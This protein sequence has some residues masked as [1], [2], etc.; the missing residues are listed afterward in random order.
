MSK[1]IMVPVHLDGFFLEQEQLAVEAFA[2][3]SELPFSG[4]DED[5]NPDTANIS[6]S[7]LS[8]PFQNTNL[9]LKRGM[10]LH[11]SLPDALTKGGTGG[12]ADDYPAVPNRWLIKR[13]STTLGNAQWVV[14]SDYMTSDLTN[15]ND[16]IAYPVDAVNPSD[17]PFV[18]LG[19]RL[20]ATGWTEVS[21]TR[22]PRLTAM[23]Y[24]EPAFA[25]FYPNCHSVFGCFDPNVDTEA[26][27]QGLS[28]QLIG[29]Y[30]DTT[31]DPLL[32]LLNANSGASQAT[33]E[34]AIQD[35]FAWNV[36]IDPLNLPAGM[37]CYA[38][39]TFDVAAN[40][41]LDNSQKSQSTTVSIGN[42]GTEA[43]SAY[44]AGQLYDNILQSD[45]ST[46]LTSIH[47]EEQLEN[48]LL[49]TQLQ[50]G[51][52]DLGARF[53]EARHAKGFKAVKGGSLWEIKP[54]NE[55]NTATSVAIGLPAGMSDALDELNS[56]QQ[57]ADQAEEMLIRQ[58][59]I[60]F[61]DWYKYM[62][63]AYPPDD[64]RDDYPDIDYVKWY[65]Q[66]QSI[67]QVTTA[68]N[69]LEEKQETLPLTQVPL[70]AQVAKFNHSMIHST[71]LSKQLDHDQADTSGLS[72][73]N[74]TWEDNSPLSTQCLSLNGI[75][76]EIS[77][78]GINGI[79]AISFWVNLD[80]QN[81]ANA[82]D[83]V[84]LANQNG[85]LISRDEITNT[86][87]RGN[88]KLVR[89]DSIER[90]HCVVRQTTCCGSIPSRWR[91]APASVDKPAA[92]VRHRVRQGK[93]PATVAVADHTA[94]I[95][96]P[97]QH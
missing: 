43:L 94:L 17:Q 46:G 4:A 12:T 62:L 63:C 15:P 36:T 1:V 39:L 57:Q 24:G 31:Q 45:P 92:T 84:L 81:S 18:Y 85:I 70:K 72:L 10:H 25:A 6:E 13:S 30:S 28:Y 71:A 66:N 86:M 58:R 19:R 47:F 93:P 75:D 96:S 11:W 51:D 34:E 7:I 16:S 97:F 35:Q 73:T 38:E 55:N 49:Q 54:A 21:A 22:L 77:I 88:H 61:A 40:A 76:A 91:A 95:L 67:P 20:E 27:L 78:T 79:K 26:D 53:K 42:T 83:T 59:H 48:L 50:S 68:K 33:L 65:I 60:L 41:T 37:V 2:D 9:N 89:A 90:W 87:R 44:L 82:N 3:F 23:G 52:L 74:T 14:E 64:S 69:D 8:P 56:L 5:Y 80:A 29:W 32:E